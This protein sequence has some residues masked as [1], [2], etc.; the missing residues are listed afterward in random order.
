M[1]SAGCCGPDAVAISERDGCCCSMP[2]HTLIIE[3]PGGSMATMEIFAEDRDEV[4]LIGHELFPGRR[5]AAV[6]QE[7]EDEE[8]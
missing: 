6:N 7:N 5:L 2:R 4:F 1:W 8:E 3:G